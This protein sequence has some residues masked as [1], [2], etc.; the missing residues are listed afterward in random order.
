MR[1]ICTYFFYTYYYKCQ[2]WYILVCDFILKYYFCECEWKPVPHTEGRMRQSNTAGRT[3]QG[4][5]IWPYVIE[6]M[7]RRYRADR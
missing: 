4:N 5:C 3:K 1:Y 7:V 2:G 6:L